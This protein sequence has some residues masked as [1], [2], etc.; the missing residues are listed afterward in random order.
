M[1]YDTRR[2]G[3]CGCCGPLGCAGM[4]LLIIVLGVAGFLIVRTSWNLY[5]IA[6]DQPLPVTRGTVLPGVY[7]QARDKLNN[8]LGDPAIRSVSLSEADVNAMLADAPE[9]G[10]LQKGVNVVFRDNEAELRLRVP[11]H[12][13]PFSTKYLNYEVFLRPII[14]GEKVTLNV[15][16][17]TS[18]GKP[19]DP[20]ALRAFQGQAEPSL[21]LLLSGLNEIRQSRAIQGVRIQNGVLLLER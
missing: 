20:I 12:L 3:G 5:S 18:G 7:P 2:Q 1:G 11:L 19:L 13:L 10:F 4:L 14:S 21:N 9:L 8:F 16:R 17:V 15:L 6:S